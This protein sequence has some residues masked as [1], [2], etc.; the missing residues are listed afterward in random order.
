M[1]SEAGMLSYIAVRSRVIGRRVVCGAY[2][3]SSV[4]RDGV[5]ATR[6]PSQQSV[7]GSGDETEP[8]V[9]GSIIG[10]VEGARG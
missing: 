4:R 1:L 3:A 5:R 7:S 10:L 6:S 9:G 8:G 2:D